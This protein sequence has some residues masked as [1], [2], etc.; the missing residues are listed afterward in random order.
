[1]K[2]N[3]SLEKQKKSSRLIVKN[4]P[5]SLDEKSLKQIFSKHGEVTDCKIM[6][7]NELNRRFAF[8]GFRFMVNAEEALNTLNQTFVKGFK[9]QVEYCALK[10]PEGKPGEQ[11]DEEFE[12]RRLFIKN[13]PYEI[14]DDEVEDLFSKFGTVTELKLIRDKEGKCIGSGFVSFDD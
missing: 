13:L 8:V 2:K 14:L 3:Q 12:K 5:P 1:M 10:K 11:Q 4:L 6:F 9:I 7:R